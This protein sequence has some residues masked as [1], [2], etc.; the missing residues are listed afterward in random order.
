QVEEVRLARTEG[1]RE[2]LNIVETCG[3]EAVREA[4]TDCI[5]RVSDFI[6][7]WRFCDGDRGGASHVGESDLVPLAVVDAGGSG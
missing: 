1:L 7:G 6:A 3:G 5:R 2:C 4:G